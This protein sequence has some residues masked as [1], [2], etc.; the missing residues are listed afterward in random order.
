MRVNKKKDCNRAD[1]GLK[2]LTARLGRFQ[3]LLESQ[4]ARLGALEKAIKPARSV[5]GRN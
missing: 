4:A 3:D 5:G 2:I 1:R